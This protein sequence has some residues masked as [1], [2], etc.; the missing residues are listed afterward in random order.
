M[1]KQIIF[2]NTTYDKKDRIVNL[3]KI[4]I[5]HSLGDNQ[6]GKTSAL[7][8]IPFTFLFNNSY[9]DSQL[10]FPDVEE[11][12][13]SQIFLKI[14]DK[15]ITNKRGGVKGQLSS[16]STKIYI[17]HDLDTSKTKELSRKE[18]EEESFF[19][20]IP[21]GFRTE[22]IYISEN[23][24][25]AFK[26]SFASFGLYYQIFYIDEK[27]GWFKYDQAKV[28]GGYA[29]YNWYTINL[30]LYSLLHDVNSIKEKSDYINKYFTT[31]NTELLEMMKID[32]LGKSY[33]HLVKANK[34]YRAY[35]SLDEKKKLELNSEILKLREKR[36]EIEGEIFKLKSEIMK[37][38]NNQD[39]IRNHTVKSME[40]FGNI[41]EN[42]NIFQLDIE[43]DINKESIEKQ[44]TSLR[45]ELSEIKRKIK[46]Q[47][48][49][50][51]NE[52]LSYSNSLNDNPDNIYNEIIKESFNYNSNSKKEFDDDL[53]SESKSLRDFFKVIKE[54]NSK[55]ISKTQSKILLKLSSE[56]KTKFNNNKHE[57]AV[58]LIEKLSKENFES[59]HFAKGALENI[60]ILS[61]RLAIVRNLNVNIPIFIVDS[62]FKGEIENKDKEEMNVYRFSVNWLLKEFMKETNEGKIK[63]LFI[64]SA[65]IMEDIDNNAF[66]E[67]NLNTTHFE[68]LFNV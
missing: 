31:N 26:N 54:E 34:I 49:N 17:S 10:N 20:G 1:I 35:N 23:Y 6:A 41:F 60:Q 22:G 29:K 9:Y 59:K 15:Y 28:K 5:F 53:K 2:K 30:Y 25:R 58:N 62:P 11:I 14:D 67:F 56:I 42:T 46:E 32:R 43:F 61:E 68:G 65:S 36:T 27:I 39:F 66:E 12:N 21:K 4:N 51:K 8:S 47:K 37:I 7:E 64:A 50:L 24:M 40:K 16:S 33:E 45:N 63:Q 55:V 18:L 38:E 19:I 52:Y 13:N 3:D 44:I 57:K 48:E